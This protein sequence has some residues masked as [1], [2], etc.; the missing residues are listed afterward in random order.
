MARDECYIKGEESNAKK[1]AGDTKKRGNTNS[2]RRNYYPPPTRDKG[3]FNFVKKKNKGTFKSQ[4][5]IPYGV[6]NFTPLNTRPEQIYKEIFHSK[7]ISDPLEPRFNCMGLDQNAW[8][9]YHTIKGHTTDDCI[10]LKRE[11]ENLI[12]DGKL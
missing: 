4:D 3:T 11:I 8:C 2:N 10:H 5:R 9:K 6:D 1:K 12:Q 7:L